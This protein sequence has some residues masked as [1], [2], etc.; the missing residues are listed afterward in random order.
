ML[1][2]LWATDKSCDG[3]SMT[4]IRV[5]IF[6]KWP[7]YQ[8]VLFYP[9]VL[10]GSISVPSKFRIVNTSLGISLHG[11][12][13]LYSIWMGPGISR[14]QGYDN[15]ISIRIIL[16]SS[17]SL[18]RPSPDLGLFKTSKD[19][20][21]LTI[22]RCNPWCWCVR[23]WQVIW[24]RCCDQEMRNLDQTPSSSGPQT[25]WSILANASFWGLL[26]LIHSPETVNE[27]LLSV[28]I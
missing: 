5:K 7:K 14:W 21:L 16:L 25:R 10:P 17:H 8:L 12:C 6:H 19:A 11:R 15:Y 22:T 20:W 23:W 4:V 13:I 26:L 2:Q 24:W 3:L 18:S 27:I 28:E 9:I 1:S